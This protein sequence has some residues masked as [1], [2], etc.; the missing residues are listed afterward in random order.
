MT[1]V[2]RWNRPAQLVLK[3]SIVPIKG[4]QGVMPLD[5]AI[6]QLEV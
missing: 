6:S 2:G 1:H 4:K 5:A 3:Y